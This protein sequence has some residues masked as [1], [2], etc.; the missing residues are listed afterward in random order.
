MW[1]LSKKAKLRKW[2]FIKFFNKY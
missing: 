2:V 1:S